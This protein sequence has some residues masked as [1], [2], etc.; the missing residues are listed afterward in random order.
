MPALRVQIAQ[1]GD[2]KQTEPACLEPERMHS[3]RGPSFRESPEAIAAA[4][5]AVSKG[6]AAEDAKEANT[7]A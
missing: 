7:R 5:R 2:D 1:V 3:F 4:M 6:A